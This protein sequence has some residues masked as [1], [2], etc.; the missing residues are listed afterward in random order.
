MEKIHA[1]YVLGLITLA[2]VVGMVAIVVFT[3]DQT[4]MSQLTIIAVS[5]L[6]NLA[7]AGSGAIG[8]LITGEII[9]RRKKGPAPELHP[10][11][12]KPKTEKYQTLT[13]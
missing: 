3:Y 2:S 1:V 8:G 7:L 13:G 12:E 9:D 4:E 5:S 11:A 6:A 10:P